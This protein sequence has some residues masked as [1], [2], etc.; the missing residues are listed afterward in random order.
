M[1]FFDD[2]SYMKVSEKR[3][4][5]CFIMEDDNGDKIKVNLDYDNLMDLADYLNGIIKVS[6]LFELLKQ[7][8]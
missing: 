5:V 3:N 7:K 8:D 6:N 2:Y 1:E 4:G